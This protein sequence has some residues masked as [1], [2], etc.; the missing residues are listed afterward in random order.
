MRFSS[1]LG[2]S[3]TRMEGRD[4]SEISEQGANMGH[5]AQISWSDCNP[6]L[7]VRGFCGDGSLLAEACFG[8]G[9]AEDE[10]VCGEGGCGRGGIE[11][12]W[13]A[14]LEVPWSRSR[15]QWRQAFAA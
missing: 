14:L 9:P 5:P 10:S 8:E 1:C 7:R 15:R 3:V 6:A 11:A 4:E 12:L 13:R 2:G